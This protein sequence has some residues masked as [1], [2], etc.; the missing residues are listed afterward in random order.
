MV[1]KLVVCKRRRRSAP[2]TTCPI[3]L[4][5]VILS[6]NPVDRHKTFLKFVLV[7]LFRSFLSVYYYR[8]KW[9]HRQIYKVKQIHFQ[10]RRTFNCF[11]SGFRNGSRQQTTTIDLRYSAISSIDLIELTVDQLGHPKM[12]WIEMK[13]ANYCNISAFESQSK[14]VYL[15]SRMYFVFF[16]FIWLVL[17]FCQSQTK[18]TQHAF[19]KSQSIGL[20]K[21]IETNRASKKWKKKTANDLI[22]MPTQTEWNTRSLTD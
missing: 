22:K 9:H 20:I 19:F 10:N 14:H 8:W 3:R 18:I 21:R 16:F 7:I 13:T 11:H 6:R 12:N 17:A 5:N 4:L 1:H 2:K 15:I